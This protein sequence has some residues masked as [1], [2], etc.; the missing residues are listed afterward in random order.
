[1]APSPFPPSAI[2][3]A[4]V[5][6]DVVPAGAVAATLR[7]TGGALVEAVRVFDEFRRDEL[8]PGRRSVAFNIRFRAADR[9]LT[10]SEVAALRQRC[11][12]AVRDAHGAELRA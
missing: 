7:A 12:D 4:F 2:D 11:I 8:G 3:L 5:L 9:T 10:D 1:V 6:G